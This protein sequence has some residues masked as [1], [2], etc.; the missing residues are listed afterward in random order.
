M[1]FINE[2]SVVVQLSIFKEYDKQYFSFIGF[3]FLEVVM[4]MVMMMM[5]KLE[6]AVAWF[7]Q[8]HFPAYS[9]KFKNYGATGHLN[10]DTHHKYC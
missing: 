10:I 3:H 7:T 6:F 1:Y 2:N 4:M 5:I 9:M 8:S